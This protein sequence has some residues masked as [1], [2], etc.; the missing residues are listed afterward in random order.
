MSF[1]STRRK[2]A[3]VAVGLAATAAVGASA[4][5][6]GGLSSDQLGAD[7]G[8]VSACDTDGID[9]EYKIAYNGRSKSHR[10]NRIVL[11]DIS[12]DCIGQAWSVTVSGVGPGA[13][14]AS[15]GGPALA[16][17]PIY[18][19]DPGPGITLSGT[20]R[21]RVRFPVSEI[22]RIS[23]VIGGRPVTALLPN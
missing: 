19:S 2:F 15:D 6:L 11:R 21:A 12:V 9:L 5:S 23:V 14:S 8:S 18:D 20:A 7:T 22:D 10:L 3:A 13:S 16:L 17:A 1:T 4:A